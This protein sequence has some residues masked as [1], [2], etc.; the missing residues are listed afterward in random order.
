MTPAIYVRYTEIVLTALSSA[1]VKINKSKRNFMLEIFMLYLSI[2][3]R[4]NFLQ[5]GR[6]SRFGEQRFR[7]QFERGFDFFSFNRAMVSPYVGPRNA[8]AFDASFIHKSGK[9]TPGIGYFWSGCAGKALRGLEVLSLSL[10]D[11]DT[12]MSFH[13]KATQTPPANC[14]TDN[15][16]S[17]PDWYAGVIKKDLV[18]ITSLTSYLVA[19]AY[20]SKRGFVDKVIAM[21]LHLVCKLRD[22]ADLLYLSKKAPTGKKGRPSKYDGKV[23]PC[24]LHADYFHEV[25]N[26]QNIKAKAAVVYS[27]SLDRNILV[28]VEEFIL[29]GKTTYRLLFSTD[30]N[31]API[32]VIDIY[33][34]RFQMEFGFR[35]AKQFAG[36]EHSQARSENKLDFHFN[37]AL[38]TVNIAKVIQL[39]D[40]TKRELPFS[41]KDTKVLFHNALLL[42]RF[43]SVFGNPPNS[44]KN[45]MYL[46]ELLTFGAIA[47]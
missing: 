34:T 43:F 45:Q 35:D 38:T 10:I 41:M 19:D 20:F 44:R 16:L 46:Q 39:K 13:L 25:K 7:R 33:H 18:Q 5:L 47:A 24:N 22:D 37:T 32:D 42:M 4:I 2:P 9:Q 30:I 12:R 36:L 17:L 1:K 15:A 26:N 31:Q 23:D 8:I 11:A 27:K 3:D 21:N 40:E 6:Y 14:L 29:K 28:I